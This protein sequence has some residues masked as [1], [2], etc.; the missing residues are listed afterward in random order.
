MKN[1]LN[2]QWI[3]NLLQGRR[4]A[5]VED[6]ISTWS[7]NVYA[8]LSTANIL[9][10]NH[11]PSIFHAVVEN[12]IDA[13]FMSCAKANYVCQNPELWAAEDAMHRTI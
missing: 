4:L 11:V 12:D 10:G 6:A 7:P 13:L 3:G 5:S 8:K 2:T 9:Q 1:I